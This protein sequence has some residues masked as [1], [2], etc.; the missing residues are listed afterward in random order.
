MNNRDIKIHRLEE[1]V[2]SGV[3]VQYTNVIFK[4]TSKLFYPLQDENVRSTF[5]NTMKR[6]NGGNLDDKILEKIKRLCFHF[7]Y[8]MKNYFCFL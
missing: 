1:C 2:P 6:S 4:S 7:I 3:S 5:I 8:N